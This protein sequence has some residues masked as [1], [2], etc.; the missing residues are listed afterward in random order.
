M[1]S[2]TSIVVWDVHPVFVLLGFLV[3][4]SLDGLFLSSALAKI[5]Q[6][7]WLTLVLAA[8]LSIFFLVWRYGKEQQWKA[9]SQ[10]RKSLSELVVAGA[11]RKYYVKRKREHEEV[12]V[13]LELANI[14]GKSNILFGSSL[15]GSST[16]HA[17]TGVGLFFDKVGELSPMVYTCFIRKFQVLHELTIFVNMLQTVR[18]YVS[19]PTVLKYYGFFCFSG[20]LTIKHPG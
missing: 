10:G 16:T 15:R 20:S 7:A 6:G 9:E 14:K 18:P 11:D 12:E 13:E 8:V 2:I 3:F 1:V 17:F 4:G 19:N 5:P